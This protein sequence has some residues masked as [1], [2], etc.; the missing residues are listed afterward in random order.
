MKYLCNQSDLNRIRNIVCVISSEYRSIDL[1]VNP[2][3]NNE[4]GGKARAR[5]SQS[6]GTFNIS[7]VRFFIGRSNISTGRKKKH[8]DLKKF[9]VLQIF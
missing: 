4:T 1:S 3:N 8:L 9:F 5:N 2:S 7:N 6:I